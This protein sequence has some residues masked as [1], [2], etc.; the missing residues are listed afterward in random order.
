MGSSASLVVAFLG[1]IKAYY[2]LPFNLH[3]YAQLLNAAIQQ[4]IGSGFDIAAALFGTQL[5]TRF[6]NI[7]QMSNALADKGKT[8]IFIDSF[9]YK[10]FFVPQVKPSLVVIDVGSGSD[11]RIMVKQILNYS[12]SKQQ[13]LFGDPLFTKLNSLYS[14]VHNALMDDGSST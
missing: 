8:N 10:P 5:Y 3:A 2:K 12:E 9:D 11:T 1:A 14:D 7:E 6:T 13:G 4:K